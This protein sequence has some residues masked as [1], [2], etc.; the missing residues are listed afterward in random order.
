MHVHD[1]PALA[2]QAVAAHPTRPATMV[3]HD[4]PDARV[5]RTRR[6][7]RMALR[8][9]ATERL[10][11][12]NRRVR[13]ARVAIADQGEERAH[14]ARIPDATER[15]ARE[16]A[17]VGFGV[18]ETQHELRKRRASCRNQRQEPRAPRAVA[19]ANR[20]ANV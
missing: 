12:G 17:H 18:G 9:G 3:I 19:Q 14:G 16:R 2:K 11:R 1:V 4:S 7:E 20:F 8:L 15:F 5:V 13:D 6:C 10:N